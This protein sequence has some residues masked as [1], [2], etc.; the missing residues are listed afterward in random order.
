MTVECLK[1]LLARAQDMLAT[2]TKLP[3]G[4][5]RKY[6]FETIRGYVSEIA[7]AMDVV[8]SRNKTGSIII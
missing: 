4:P 7:K 6:A 2:A 3:P 5:S 8:E 1:D